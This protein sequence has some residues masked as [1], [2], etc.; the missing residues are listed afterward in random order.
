[1]TFDT[2]IILNLLLSSSWA[3]YAHTYI[4]T[5]YYIR[6]SFRNFLMGGGGGG[7]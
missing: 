2:T 3:T 4:H 7:E 1:M 5:Y 6:A